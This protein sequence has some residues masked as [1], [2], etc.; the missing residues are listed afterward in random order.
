MMAAG[1]LLLH[2]LASRLFHSR[3]VAPTHCCIGPLDCP[4]VE[5]VVDRGTLPPKSVHLP[6]AIVDKVRQRLPESMRQR[7][8][9]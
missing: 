1:H 9:R 7:V 8:I 6:G 2:L 4:Q 5:R 3:C